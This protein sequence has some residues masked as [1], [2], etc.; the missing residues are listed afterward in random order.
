MGSP[1][2]EN[3]AAPHQPAGC[4]KHCEERITHG[5]AT[6]NPCPPLVVLAPMGSTKSRRGRTLLSGLA[7][8]PTDHATKVTPAA[9]LNCGMKACDIDGASH[10]HSMTALEWTN[11]PAV[12]G[13]ALSLVASSPPSANTE[14]LLLKS[15]AGKTGSRSGC[16]TMP[17]AGTEQR[18]PKRSEG[19]R[20]KRVAADE[21]APSA[22]AASCGRV[23]AGTLEFPAEA[24]AVDSTFTEFHGASPQ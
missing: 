17:K 21:A 8:R 20:A 16:R 13:G 7:F 11:T 19:A 18:A 9:P 6:T 23:E 14:N 4:G 1:P 3:E 12:S 15:H 5:K 24:F 10:T 22:S 2:R